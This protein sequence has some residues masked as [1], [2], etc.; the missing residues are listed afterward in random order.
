MPALSL[1]RPHKLIPPNPDAKIILTALTYF[2]QSRLE[3]YG[4]HWIVRQTE[5]YDPLY[6]RSSDPLYKFCGKLTLII[7]PLLDLPQHRRLGFPQDEDFSWDFL[8]NS[9]RA[10]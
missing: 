8:Q 9:V 3:F 2:G 4:P 7:S 5:V 1:L 6:Y 10:L